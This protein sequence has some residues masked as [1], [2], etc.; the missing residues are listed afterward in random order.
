MALSNRVNL[1]GGGG[2]ALSKIIFKDGVFNVP[3]SANQ[4]TRSGYSMTMPSLDSDGNL[5]IATSNNSNYQIAGTAYSIDLTDIDAVVFKVKTTAAYNNI[6]IQMAV[7]QTTGIG[8][9]ASV[10]YA[11]TTSVTPDFLDFTINTQNLTGTYY[12]W[13]S[14]VS[15]LRSG[16][17]SEIYL[18]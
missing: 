18:S 13:V 2:E 9:D 14:T 12:I 11:Q 10:V 6:G 7:Q 1:R 3:M 15:T 17:V 16:L 8:T 4:F 5:I